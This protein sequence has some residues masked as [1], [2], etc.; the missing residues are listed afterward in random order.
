MRLLGTDF[1]VSLTPLDPE[2]KVQTPSSNSELSTI[3]NGLEG[4]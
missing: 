2:L 3:G 4:T 1:Y